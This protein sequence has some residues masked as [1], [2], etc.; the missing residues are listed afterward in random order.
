MIVTMPSGSKRTT[1]AAWALSARPSDLLGNRLE[2]L[3]RAT[4]ARDERSDPQ[5]RSCLIAHRQIT[6]PVQRALLGIVGDRAGKTDRQVSDRAFPV[7]SQ[8]GTVSLHRD[9]APRLTAGQHR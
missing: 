1:F 9:K 7:V 6:G 5:Q 3:V 8:A 2:D 4:A